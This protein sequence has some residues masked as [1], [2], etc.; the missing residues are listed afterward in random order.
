VIYQGPCPLMPLVATGLLH[1]D[2]YWY[3]K[4]NGRRPEEAPIVL[5]TI[6][7]LT[8]EKEIDRRNTDKQMNK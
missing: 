4:Q 3:F 2:V 1:T 8:D 6:D 5:A 7:R